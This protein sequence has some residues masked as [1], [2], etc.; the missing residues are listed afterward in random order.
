MGLKD[1][2][3]SIT[4]PFWKELLPSDTKYLIC[5]RNPLDVA[6]SMKRAYGIDQSRGEEVW[7]S[8]TLN[9]IMNTMNERRM[10]VIYDDYFERPDKLTS[11]VEEFSR[12]PKERFFNHSTYRASSAF[13]SIRRRHQSESEPTSEAIV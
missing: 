4:L 12:F 1:P 11:G 9:A 2:R 7:L 10:F 6:K 8:Y 13:Q 5:V 3:L